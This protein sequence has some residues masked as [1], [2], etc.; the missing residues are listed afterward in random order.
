MKC[1][2]KISCV[3]EN[4]KEFYIGSTKDLY[5]RKIN[6]KS[7]CNNLNSNSYHYPLYQFIRKNGGIDNW[8]IIVEVETP[9]HTKEERLELEQIYIELLKP[10]LNI[11][12]PYGF[13]KEKYSKDYREKNKE[14]CKTY[15]HIYKLNNKEKDSVYNKQYK[16]T[17][18]YKD[19]M[20]E[21]ANKKNCPHC[22]KEMRK[23][24]IK[25]HIKNKH[26]TEKIFSYN[27]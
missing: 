27:L 23:D 15:N 6:H 22:N 26:P 19:Y 1:V 9:N 16:K 25:R 12:N 20:I 3:D 24:N 14:K 7:C 5:I 10:Q 8:E 18:N 17:E 4:I 11:N 13:D 21:R 2:Y